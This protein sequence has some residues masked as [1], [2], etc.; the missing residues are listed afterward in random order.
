[1]A[2]L[3]FGIVLIG[4]AAAALVIAGRSGGRPPAYPVEPPPAVATPAAPIVSDSVPVQRPPVDSPAVVTPPRAA[5][6][7]RPSRW[8]SDWVNV[9]SGR[10]VEDSVVTGLRRGRRVEVGERVEGWWMVYSD[11]RPLGWVAG[12]LLSSV[13]VDTMGA[14]PVP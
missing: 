10:S 3:V 12:E 14:T 11:G 8:T 4:A 1:M 13:P 5:A 2:S 9:R 7:S 6:P